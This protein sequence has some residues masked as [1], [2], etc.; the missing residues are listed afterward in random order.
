M[1]SAICLGRRSGIAVLLS[2]DARSGLSLGAGPLTVI[3]RPTRA[4][5][6]NAIARTFSDADV[7]WTVA[8]AMATGYVRQAAES[9]RWHAPS[10]V[11]RPSVTLVPVGRGAGLREAPS[12]RNG[13]RRIAADAA[14]PNAAGAP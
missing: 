3:R 14:R 4:G 9:R 10:R 6:A 13:D 11:G 5:A 12:C 1:K 7:S 2:R 8:V